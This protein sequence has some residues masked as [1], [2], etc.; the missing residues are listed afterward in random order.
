MSCDPTWEVCDTVAK[1]D[2][3]ATAS[4]ENTAVLDD[5]VV[6]YGADI[7]KSISRTWA[8]AAAG[9]FWTSYSWYTACISAY[10]AAASVN[11]ITTADQD[12]FKS[13]NGWKYMTYWIYLNMGWG[14]LSLPVWTANT[15]IGESSGIP[16]TLAS[17]FSK[18]SGLV[19]IAGMVIATLWYTSIVKEAD[20]VTGTWD[21]SNNWATTA[22][23]VTDNAKLQKRLEWRDFFFNSAAQTMLAVLT[24]S[25]V[26]A[27]AAR[28]GNCYD[29]AGAVIDCPSDEAT[30]DSAAAQT[31]DADTAAEEKPAD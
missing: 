31:A 15:F 8:I 23:A 22:T 1:A 16:M 18:V 5:E 19:G 28:A 30:D 6:I 10:S 29:D 14:F 11:N 21:A 13:V 24:G 7:F 17:V 3:A 27:A 2:A 25:A 9:L 20:A 12:L 26:S 4:T